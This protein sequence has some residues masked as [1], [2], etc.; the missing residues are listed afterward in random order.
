MIAQGTGNRPAIGDEELHRERYVLP[1]DHDVTAHPHMMTE[2]G[3]W[4]TSKA[5]VRRTLEKCIHL[6]RQNRSTGQKQDEYEAFRL[7]GTAVRVP[8][9]SD[10]IVY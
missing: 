8:P 6:G 4:D 9:M 7:L 5:L 1:S 3:H 2:S 10:D